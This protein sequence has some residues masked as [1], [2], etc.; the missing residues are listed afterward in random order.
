MIPREKNG[1]LIVRCHHKKLGV[2]GHVSQKKKNQLQYINWGLF[3]KIYLILYES[4]VHIALYNTTVEILPREQVLGHQLQK[5][6]FQ[7]LDL[8]FSSGRKD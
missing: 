6:Q 5:M 4:V 3:P 2:L 7:R 1:L 8:K